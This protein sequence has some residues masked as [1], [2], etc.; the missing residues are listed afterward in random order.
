VLRAETNKVG[1]V[2]AATIDIALATMLVPVV[3]TTSGSSGTSMMFSTIMPALAVLVLQ[4]LCACRRTAMTPETQPEV[5]IPVASG[6]SCT[7]LVRPSKEKSVLGM[8]EKR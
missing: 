1:A 3:K 4:L 7:P 2:V 5:S 8:T 6:R